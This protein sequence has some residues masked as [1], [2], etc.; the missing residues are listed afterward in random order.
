VSRLHLVTLQ[1]DHV[2]PNLKVLTAEAGILKHNGGGTPVNADRGNPV[3]ESLGNLG[4]AIAFLHAEFLASEVLILEEARTLMVPV[5]GI[6]NGHD[7]EGG[8]AVIPAVPGLDLE[9]LEVGDI[10]AQAETRLL[11][12][13]A[14]IN[15]HL[16][17]TEDAD[18]GN[19]IVEP[20][21]NLRHAL[22]RPDAKFLA[23]EVDIPEETRAPAV[24][25][26]AIPIV[27]ITILISIPFALVAILCA[28]PSCAA[29]QRHD[30]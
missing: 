25:V 26:I 27:V 4:H 28:Q 6:P 15:G 22:A 18:G 8:D 9:S 19:V 13:A 12:V 7:F 24:L 21:W 30:K 29:N 17:A 1:V 11:K 20:G 14:L 10:L 2:I 5:A 23:A 3:A 16:S